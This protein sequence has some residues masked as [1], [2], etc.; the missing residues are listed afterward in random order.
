MLHCFV[1]PE[2]YYGHG[3]PVPGPTYVVDKLRDDARAEFEAVMAGLDWAGLEHQAVFVESNP[4]TQILEMQDDIDLVVMG[5]HG[6]TGLSSM[7]L[8]NVTYTI[9][10]EGT[11]PV[12]A[13][14]HPE[15]AWKL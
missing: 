5:T 2:L 9:I 6:R 3:Y 11:V 1:S 8:G 4:A 7:I 10:R 13:L 14:R 12:V 15:R